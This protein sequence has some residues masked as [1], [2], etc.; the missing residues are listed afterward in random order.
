MARSIVSLG[1]LPALASRM[2]LRRRALE[3]GSPP[4]V[5]AA[6]VISLMNLVKSL[7]R[8]A[9]VAPF[10][11]LMLCHFECPDIPEVFLNVVVKRVIRN[12][13]QRAN[14][15]IE[16]GW[17]AGRQAGRQRSLDDR[18]PFSISHLRFFICH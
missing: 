6:T 4:P 11:C 2:A 17:L 8:L 16:A 1:M 9:S 3:S 12:I 15:N 13:T 14:T 10:L 7:P 5:R 18:D